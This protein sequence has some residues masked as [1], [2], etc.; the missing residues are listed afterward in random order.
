VHSNQE[1]VATVIKK[2]PSQKT[3]HRP[4]RPPVKNPPELITGFLYR[5][6]YTG[7]DI[8][9]RPIIPFESKNLRAV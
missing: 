9:L 1:S 3:T 6:K 5:N 2:D 7:L 8:S 4:K